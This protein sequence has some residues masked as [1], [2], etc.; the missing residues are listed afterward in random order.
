[1]ATID[2][3]KS[4][5]DLYTAKKTVQEV[6][7]GAGTFLAMDGQGEPGGTAF[8]EAVRALYSVAFTVKFASKHEGGCD[9]KVNKL[10]CLYLSDPATTPAAEWQWRLLVRIPDEVSARHV[11]DAKK[12]VCEKK[13]ADV[14]AVKRIR[15]KEGPALQVLHMGPYDQVGP[16]Y[17]QLQTFAEAKGWEVSC[18]A[19]EIYLSD[20][21]MTAPERIKTIVRLGVKKP[22]ARKKT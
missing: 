11:S 15:W 22:R 19:H 5:K 1:M 3:A 7:P 10:E 17:A 2:F 21:R 9:F 20:P 6:S 14:A 16:T 8:Q 18:P 13:G 12:A 4:L